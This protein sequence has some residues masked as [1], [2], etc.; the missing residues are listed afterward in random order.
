[1]KRAGKATEE[2]EAPAAKRIRRSESQTIFKFKEHCIFSGEKCL[3]NFDSKHPDRWR[4]VVLC[5]TADRKDQNTFKQSIIDTC[6]ARQDNISQQVKMRVLSSVSDLHAADARYHKDCRDNF[7][8]PRN[9]D[10][11]RKR[12]DTSHHDVDTAFLSVTSEMQADM[13]RIWN[14]IEVH[15]LYESKG[16]NCL[17]RRNLVMKLSEHFGSDL[18]VLSGRGV[19]NILV[20]QSKASN[21]LRLVHKQEDDEVEIALEAISRSILHESKE[22]ATDKRY[23]SARVELNIALSS[24]SPTLLWQNC[25]CLLL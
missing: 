22:L 3:M 21:S 24:V 16:E 14:S 6:E 11:V 17:S 4:R 8:A 18:L 7:M 9:V 23:Y 1:L 25:R 13:S 19:A 2:H 12:M 15:D 5:R 20:F 10:S